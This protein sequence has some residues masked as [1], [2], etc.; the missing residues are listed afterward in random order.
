[1]RSGIP[2]E[3][4]PSVATV[5]GPGAIRIVELTGN[6]RPRNIRVL[7]L[8]AGGRIRWFH[9]R[10]FSASKLLELDQAALVLASEG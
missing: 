5:Y 10:G 8:D 1:M 7:L 2:S 3:D 6:E 4:W 9:D